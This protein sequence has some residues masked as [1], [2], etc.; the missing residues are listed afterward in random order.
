M[1]FATKIMRPS[2]L[3]VMQVSIPDKIGKHA[4]PLL[5]HVQ[6]DADNAAGEG[7]VL[8]VAKARGI[9][10]CKRE[11]QFLRL[12]KHMHA[13]AAEV[14]TWHHSNTDWVGLVVK[15]VSASSAYGSTSRH[16]CELM[17]IAPENIQLVAHVI[18]SG[19]RAPPHHAHMQCHTLLRSMCR[20]AC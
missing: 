19:S 15:F 17:Q 1:L 11:L 7:Y 12:Q 20:S 5:C 13:C 10:E 16:F 18:P 8:L 9:M 14:F 3:C 4:Q 2:A 6:L